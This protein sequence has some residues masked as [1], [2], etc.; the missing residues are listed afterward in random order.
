MAAMHC[1]LPTG[2][3]R[4]SPRH[5][6]LA[7]LHARAASL[8]PWIA[9]AIGDVEVRKTL[10]FSSVTQATA[11]ADALQH[12]QPRHTENMLS[13]R[14]RTELS[15]VRPDGRLNELPV[16]VLLAF[17][18]YPRHRCRQLV[19]V[20]DGEHVRQRLG[21]WRDLRR[22]WLLHSLQLHILVTVHA[23]AGLGGCRTAGR[24]V[25]TG[26]KLLKSWSD[27]LGLDNRGLLA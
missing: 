25:S 16:S 15:S 11:I 8:D 23:R 2:E 22:R 19:L 5:R 20:R 1:S 3:V 12:S 6:R 26:V 18:P 9:N 4:R 7:S 14:G 24:C 27:P 13:V 10:P 17:R 21:E